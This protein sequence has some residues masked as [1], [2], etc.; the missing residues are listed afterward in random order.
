[1]Q[2]FFTQALVLDRVDAG[3]ADARV[4]L[5]TEA[6]GR[7][8][9]RARSVRKITSKL[10][11]HLQ[12]YNII[13]ARILEHSGF[14]IV[15]ALRI[16]RFKPTKNF[17]ELC[18][19]IR[20]MSAEGHPDAGIWAEL[21][22]GVLQGARILKR[23]GLDPEHARCHGC[24]AAQPAY[25]IPKDMQYLCASCMKTRGAGENYFLLSKKQ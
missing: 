19:L 6:R 3:E 22:G 13:E 2:E 24:E 25:F 15:D 17:T 21:K 14:Q 8:S 4:F 20:Q 11:V 7:I 1:M 9:A 18:N 23:L 10:A 16:G 5:F 12:P